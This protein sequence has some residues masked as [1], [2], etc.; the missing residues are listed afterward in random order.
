MAKKTSNAPRP[1][2]AFFIVEPGGM[3]YPFTARSQRKTSI[4]DFVLERID[5]I[6][7]QDAW[8]DDFL[9]KGWSC[10]RLRILP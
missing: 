5:G 2:T 7:W 9:G 1:T 6:L 10:R 3:V 4:Q 8:R